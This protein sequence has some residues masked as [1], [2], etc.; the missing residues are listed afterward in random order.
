MLKLQKESADCLRVK[1]PLEPEPQSLVTLAMDM[2]DLLKGF[3]A[4]G[5]AAPQVG[6]L[7]RLFVMRID[8]VDWLCVNPQWQPLG[9]AP[10]PMDEGCVT[11]RGVCVPV[12][13][14]PEI[15]AQW[16]DPIRGPQEQR[17]EG[18]AA[19]C[20]QHEWDH[21]EGRTLREVAEPRHWI[22]ALRQRRLKSPFGR[23]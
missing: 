13:R 7:R 11:F 16:V 8:Q 2:L 9:A 17:L 12:L 5:L 15:S 14:Y 4:V 19:Q 20:F 22:W 10:K 3:Q 21:L 1:V 23:P 6:Q 18:L